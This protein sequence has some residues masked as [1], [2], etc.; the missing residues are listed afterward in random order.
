MISIDNKKKYLCKILGFTLAE[1][2][3][4]L[5]II[6]IV[7]EMTI[8][9]LINNFQTKVTITNLKKVYSEFS[10]AYTLSAQE[11]GT[12]DTWGLTEGDAAGAVTLINKFIPY[13]RIS[14]QCVGTA[15]SDY[16]GCFPDIVYKRLDNDPS[17]NINSLDI[18]QKVILSD[19]T[20]VAFQVTSATCNPV[21]GITNNPNKGACG[22]ITVD[23]NGFK[24]PNQLG[25]DVFFF[26]ITKSGI[27]PVGTPEDT[28]RSQITNSGY[29][30]A[31]W[32]LYNE[33]MDYLKCNVYWNGPTTCP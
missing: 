6:G 20:L 3:I 16:K 22:G 32:V 30:D 8:P 24:S 11:N 25:K 17:V 28:N 7:A 27:I 12:P 5:G 4:V 15:A 33:N 31:A 10:Q 9:T 2:L 29:G 14:K 18:Y 23:I 19:G 26:W 13:L 21:Y 1:V